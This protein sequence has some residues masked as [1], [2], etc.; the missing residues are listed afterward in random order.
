MP[1]SP[2]TALFVDAVTVDVPSPQEYPMG[3]SLWRALIDVPVWIME[4][5]DEKAIGGR[6]GILIC[7]PATSITGRT[8][9]GLFTHF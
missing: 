7:I 1:V 5:N 8:K 4:G 2:L 3:A 6:W 9:L